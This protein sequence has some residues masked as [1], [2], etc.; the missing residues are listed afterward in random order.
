MRLFIVVTAFCLFACKGNQQ[1]KVPDAKAPDT[2]AKPTP[3]VLDT[4]ETSSAKVAEKIDSANYKISTRKTL[5]NYEI[6][7]W[8]N[9]GSTQLIVDNKLTHKKDTLQLDGISGWSGRPI[10]IKDITQS[11]GI[12]RLTIFLTWE[13]DSDND[14]SEVVG[15]QQDTLKEL[16]Q[17]PGAGGLV[18][19]KRKDP[20]TLVGHAW[21]E[22]D[23]VRGTHGNY[24]VTVSL[25]DYDV[26]VDPP[27]TLEIDEDK[28]VKE[29]IH[30]YRLSAS[31]KLI[32]RTISPGR[33]IHVDTIYYLQQMVSFHLNDSTRLT[34]PHDSISWRL[35]VSIAG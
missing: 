1:H 32:P 27:D 2:S 4:P 24:I 20:H 13:G 11:V 5:G 23:V 19:L 15:Y 9:E 12:G 30:A 33:K 26:H 29:T 34:V 21:G 16:F 28:E 31:G 18:D 17:I 35:K 8:G 7:I 6:S 10:D 22:D 3:I 14:Y 25:P